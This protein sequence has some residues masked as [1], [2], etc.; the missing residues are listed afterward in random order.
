LPLPVARA[1]ITREGSAGR[2]SGFFTTIEKPDF[3]HR[4]VQAKP[5]TDFITN[6]FKI[7]HLHATP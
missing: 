5:P 1:G 6:P 3:G 2:V 4:L 7:G